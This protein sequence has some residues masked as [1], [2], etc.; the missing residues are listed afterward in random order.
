MAYVE[1]AIYV[2]LDVVTKC[3]E[4]A[5]RSVLIEGRLVEVV[6]YRIQQ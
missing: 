1:V 6:L 3:A 5:S 4:H 2:D